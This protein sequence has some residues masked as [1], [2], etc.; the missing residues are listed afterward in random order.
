MRCYRHFTVVRGSRLE[1]YP[2]SSLALHDNRQKA[3]SDGREGYG[4]CPDIP[5]FSH[6]VYKAYDPR[7]KV[8]APLAGMLAETNPDCSKMLHTAEKLEEWIGQFR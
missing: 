8:L 3:D 4:H 2:L 6:R 5:G 7:A 1:H